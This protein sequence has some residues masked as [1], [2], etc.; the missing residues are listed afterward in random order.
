LI[1]PAPAMIF[2]VSMNPDL[3]YFRNIR[4]TRQLLDH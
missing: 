3:A 1:A 4:L 2:G